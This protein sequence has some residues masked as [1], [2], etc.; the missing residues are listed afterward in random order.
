METQQTI[1]AA[2]ADHNALQKMRVNGFDP[3]AAAA[4]YPLLVAAVRDLQA[5]LWE[6]RKRDVRKNFALMNAEA[7][8][9]KLLR[10]LGEMP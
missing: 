2:L 3:L 9:L 5:S 6:D 8:A 10:E 4:A 7:C 1:A